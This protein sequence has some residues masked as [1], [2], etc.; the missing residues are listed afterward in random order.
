MIS[1]ASNNF[2]A[3]LFAPIALANVTAAGHAPKRPLAHLKP[4]AA[5]I[6]QIGDQVTIN[7]HPFVVGYGLIPVGSGPA[8]T[9]TPTPTPVPT[10][11]P[12]PTPTPNPT[13]APDIVIYG[14]RD[15]QRNPALAFLPGTTVYI[16]GVNF[17]ARA[18]TVKVGNTVVLPQ[19][20]RDTQIEILCP[21][22]PIGAKTGPVLLEIR[23]PDGSYNQVMGFTIIAPPGKKVDF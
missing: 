17:G 7:G 21:P 6:L 13:P 11:T 4:K 10:P 19:S 8:P 20:W 22:L 2:L 15:A 1:L 12:T 18:G 9:P 14:Y 5:I 16:E 3:A 23:R